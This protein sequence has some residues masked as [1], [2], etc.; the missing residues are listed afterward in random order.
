VICAA[1]AGVGIALASRGARCSPLVARRAVTDEETLDTAELLKK[2]ANQIED[3]RTASGNLL[4]DKD[5]L[6]VLRFAIEHKGNPVAAS[7]NVKEV[8]EWRSGIG[9]SMVDSAAEAVAKAT[10]GGGWNNEPVLS[11]APHSEKVSKFLTGSQIVVVTLPDGDLCSC[12]RASAIDDKKLM[13]D[14]TVQ[15]MVDFFIYCREVNFLVA[16]K[17][18][19]DSG[20]LC[21]LLAA[22]DLTGVSKFPDSRFQEALT[23]SS[24]M[25][26]MLYPGFSGPT[27]I[28]N[29]PGIVRLLVT[30]LT[31]LFPGAVQQ[32]LKFARGPMAYLKDLKDVLKEPIKS[33]FLDDMQA[34]LKA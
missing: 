13:D 4:K 20:R 27:V 15:E 23:G 7:K 25:A 28:L 31:P 32:R 21:R 17:R 22:N 11:A 24:K 8:M 10:E 18:T 5:D 9:K 33:Q 12:I 16:Q 14:V 30:F 1:F 2:Y 6:Y 3:V 26:T 34:V 29:L 19:Q